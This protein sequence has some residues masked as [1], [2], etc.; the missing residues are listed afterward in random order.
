MSCPPSAFD[1]VLPAIANPPSRV[2][3]RVLQKSNSE[4]PNVRRH[5]RVPRRS[6]ATRKTSLSSVDVDVPANAYPP[7]IGTTDL[8]TS[9]PSPQATRVD[10]ST[11]PS[12]PV[13]AI[14]ASLPSLT[15]PTST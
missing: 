13:F 4:P 5:R 6:V 11:V 3:T 8:A 2:P 14:Q 15:A 10:H 9:T 1:C 12:G 7:E